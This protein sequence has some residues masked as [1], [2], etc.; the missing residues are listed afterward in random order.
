MATDDESIAPGQ[1]WQDLDRRGGATFRIR[2]VSRMHPPHAYVTDLN[3]KRLRRVLL[4]RFRAH[5]GY[6]T[7]Y[8]RR[9]ELEGKEV[10]Q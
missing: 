7:G 4:D 10:D 9:R 3:G 2:N 6:R 1:V 5:D 8:A